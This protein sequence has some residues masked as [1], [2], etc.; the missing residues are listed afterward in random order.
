MSRRFLI[1]F[2]VVALLG[3]LL[4]GNAGADRLPEFKTNELEYLDAMARMGITDDPYEML[5]V[6]YRIC[7]EL[8]RGHSGAELAQML[9]GPNPWLEVDNAEAFLCPD[10]LWR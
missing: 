4:A 6:G 8:V 10:R 1:A 2:G 9:G 3:V 7:T 5:D